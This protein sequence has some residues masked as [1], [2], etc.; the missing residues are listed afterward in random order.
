VQFAPG[1]VLLAPFT[2]AFPPNVNAVKHPA[3]IVLGVAEFGQKQLLGGL[4]LQLSSGLLIG[5][6]PGL[7]RGSLRIT[8]LVQ[9]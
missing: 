9:V 7:F 3:K 2:K 1:H 8:L 6:E 5:D 4:T